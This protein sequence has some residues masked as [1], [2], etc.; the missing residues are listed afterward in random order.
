ML[1]RIVILLLFVQFSFGQV[2]EGIELCFEYKRAV[3]A[4]TSD[5]EANEALDKILSVIGA[6]KN[7]TLTPCDNIFNALAVT[8]KGER[9]IL[10]DGEFMKNISELTNDWSST[11]I[12]AHE[13]GHHIN[14]HTRDFLLASILD[15]NSLA[16]ERQEE[17]EAD[18][19]AGFVLAKL[20]ASLNQTIAAVDLITTN[21][22][23]TYSTHPSKNKRIEAIREG[24]SGGVT[25]VASNKSSSNNS[26]RTSSSVSGYWT[27]ER[28]ESS[29]FSDESEPR[30][31]AYVFGKLNPVKNNFSQPKLSIERYNKSHS[32]KEIYYYYDKNDYSNRA[33]IDNRLTY[34]LK[35]SNLKINTYSQKTTYNNTSEYVSN[36]HPDCERISKPCRMLVTVE[37]VFDDQAKLSTNDPKNSFVWGR[38]IYPEIKRSRENPNQITEVSFE[39]YKR[40][41]QNEN[42]G[43]SEYPHIGKR[44]VYGA[45]VPPTSDRFQSYTISEYQS[46]WD[47]YLINYLK[48]KSKVF[49]KITVHD[50]HNE[51]KSEYFEFSLSGSTKALDFLIPHGNNVP[52]SR[53]NKF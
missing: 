26:P 18:K 2:K 24:Y 7:F 21:D 39:F 52:G 11:F 22:D 17:L 47:E 45:L 12:L 37:L 33:D 48:T 27:K 28:V 35:I 5:K 23:D 8:Y 43:Y 44:E 16:K 36:Y 34:V 30:N 3:S 6:S 49:I 14:G 15:D 13:V 25:R 42:Y 31:R 1:K 10:Y 41:L 38:R 20:G 32:T 51:H 19:F 40:A 29:P 46:V 9:Y 53:F 4:F 50:Q